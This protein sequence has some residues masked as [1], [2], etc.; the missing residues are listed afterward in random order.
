MTLL[1]TQMPAH[2]HTLHAS[3]T[4]GTSAGPEGGV[5]AV[6]VDPTSQQPLNAYATQANTTMN[7]QAISNTGGNQPHD[8]MQPYLV[9]NFIIALVGIYPSH[10]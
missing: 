6:T 4:P 5:S 7:P 2:N 9:V 8:N 3:N 1:A 10:S